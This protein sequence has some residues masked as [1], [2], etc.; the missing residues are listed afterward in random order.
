MKIITIC[1]E[2]G[3]GGRELGKR[4]SDALGIP[5]YDQQIIE[6]AAEQSGYDKDYVARLSERDIRMS[7]PATIAHSFNSVNK[8][9]LPTL[10][11]AVAQQK[12]IKE[13]AEHG[14]CVI[15]GRCSD[16]ILQ[17]LDPMNI[18]VY[19]SKESKIA[20]CQSRMT[21]NEHYSANEIVSMMRKIDKD[22]KGF[23]EMLTDKKW[24][25]KESYHL[26][27]NTSDKEIKALIPGLAEYVRCWFGDNFSA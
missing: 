14:D 7:Y 27:V 15:I 23:R 20:R 10:E 26:C 21:D 18:F 16:I 8:I 13:L 25:S 12:I 9:I 6:M 5:C 22:R 19:A 1:R 11:I 24:G 4:L 2:F 3:S 17:Y